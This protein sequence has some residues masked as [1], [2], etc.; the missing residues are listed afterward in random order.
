MEGRVSAPPREGSV[1]GSSGSRARVGVGGR[2]L[3]LVVLVVAVVGL[4]GCIG[5]GD[6]ALVPEGVELEVEDAEVDESGGE[7]LTRAS[8]AVDDVEGYG[9]EGETAF[10]FSSWLFGYSA[11]L[12]STGEVDAVEQ[13]ALVE[14]EG[15]E[16]V[17]LLSLG[18]GNDFSST[19]Y[20]DV[21]ST[22]VER[23]GGGDGVNR[24]VYPEG[25]PSGVPSAYG[26]HGALDVVE[27]GDAEVLGVSSVDDDEAVVLS[28]DVSASTLGE[29]VET[30]QRFHGPE[31]EDGEGGDLDGSEDVHVRETYVWLD[32][33]SHLPLRW[34][35]YME[36]EF[37][38]DDE[39]SD[40]LFGEMGG[41]AA[42]Y[43]TVQYSG[44]D[45]E[46]DVDAPD[47]LHEW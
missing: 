22:Y 34:A 17:E 3:A 18:N 37:E 31:M 12:N 2:Y 41:T 25:Y 4:S 44:Y 27:S 38:G 33:D 13:R 1:S 45:D 36:M 39:D 11:A 16:E 46:V 40:A 20:T 9:V 24:S 10:G 8:D 42:F 6:V 35:Y 5:D 28:V 14:S 32:R 26:L 23:R 47:G 19:A 30:V 21:N 29:H 15:R 7:L 43:L